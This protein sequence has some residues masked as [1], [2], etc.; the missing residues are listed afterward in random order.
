[1]GSLLGIWS[2]KTLGDINIG[3]KHSNGKDKSEP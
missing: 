1:M 3:K 2:M